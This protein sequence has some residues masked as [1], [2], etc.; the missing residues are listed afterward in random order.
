MRGALVVVMVKTEIKTEVG[1]TRAAAKAVEN[2]S[3]GEQWQN[4][5]EICTNGDG[6]GNDGGSEGG[7]EGAGDDGDE[8]SVDDRGQRKRQWR[9]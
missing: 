6:H 4:S 9:Q 7:G 8:S 3:E 1:R 2:G 5:G